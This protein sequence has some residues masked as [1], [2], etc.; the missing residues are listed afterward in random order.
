MPQFVGGALCW[1]IKARV[2][3][4]KIRNGNKNVCIWQWKLKSI[5]SIIRWAIQSTNVLNNYLHSF[6]SAYSNVSLSKI[7]SFII[8]DL[9]L[10]RNV[11]QFDPR[12]YG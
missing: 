8:R 2:E 4:K 11:E 9:V 12:L 1:T 5:Y 3:Q 10:F 7:H 6:M